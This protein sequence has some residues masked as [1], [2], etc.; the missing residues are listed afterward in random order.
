MKT[1]VQIKS[2][3]RLV[4]LIS[5]A[6]FVFMTFAFFTACTS[7]DTTSKATPTQSLYSKAKAE[8]D[9]KNYGAAIIDFKQVLASNPDISTYEL[10][11]YYLSLSYYYSLDYPAAEA[12]LNKFLTKF[13][14]TATYYY[15]AYYWR[16]RARQ[17]QNNF[18]GAI[19]DYTMV[20]GSTS[21]YV[22]NAQFQIGN[23]H[24]ENAVFLLGTTPPD[25]VG[26]YAKLNLAGSEFDTFMTNNATS[27]YYDDAAY[28][29]GRVFQ[30][31]AEAL[32]LDTAL[33]TVNSEASRYDQARSAYAAFENNANL[34]A[35]VYADA[36]LYF[37]ARTY[38]SQT[39]FNYTLARSQFKKLIDNTAFATSTWRDDAQ[40]QVS[41]TY[42]D[43]AV[44]LIATDP[45][46]ALQK[47]ETAI[48][49]F[50]LILRSP[51]NGQSFADNN[52]W[53]NAL[54]YRGR[55]LE[56]M[57]GLVEA[58][59]SA[60]AT[61][62]NLTQDY[63][64]NPALT[65]PLAILYE[66]SRAAF[67]A[68]MSFNSTSS[69]ADNAQLEIG[70]LLQNQAANPN[71][72][73]NN[74]DKYNLLA[75]A[76]DAYLA[77]LALPI[78]T[79]TPPGCSSDDNA[80][81]N[82]G[83]VYADTLAITQGTAI[84]PNPFNQDVTYTLARNIFT[85]FIASYPASIWVD[86]AYYQMADLS[87]KEGSIAGNLNQTILERAL[88]DYAQVILY[89]PAGQ[90]VD[91]AIYYIGD[92][93][94]A[95]SPA[96]NAGGCQLAFDWY[97]VYIGLSNGNNYNF[98]YNGSNPVAINAANLTLSATKTSAAQTFIDNYNI[99]TYDCIDQLAGQ[100][101]TTII[102]APAP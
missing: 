32:Q 75:Q 45:L 13:D 65:D 8:Y 61:L 97:S 41:I 53:D 47:L 101:L 18:D 38:Q 46:T 78:C 26:A 50:N 19:A 67:Q 56:R 60:P 69:Y 83:K 9:A 29:S 24:Y 54:Y 22:D 43:E 91:N 16:G 92:L 102:T 77:V 98:Q 90:Y 37:S 14:N 51:G 95:N 82:L 87:R 68:L 71:L 52:R 66:A 64:V 85:Q 7:D 88:S 11:Q 40:Y 72:S 84:V 79:T 49:E 100:S 70:V 63:T 76:E 94:Q 31:M 27:S 48:N 15:A 12:E 28:F 6:L 36:A 2:G 74:S 62:A 33:D 57:T 3:H 25:L 93:Y 59:Q 20:L 89:D 21:V 35:S 5:Y 34:T 55:A 86:N 42:Y 23:A 10:A 4:K 80:K 1:L 58:G 39:A 99:A 81:Y 96:T 30:R 44:A 73:P 17:K